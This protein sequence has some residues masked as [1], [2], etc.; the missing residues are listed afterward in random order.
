MM[1][2]WSE[3][4][5]HQGKLK[6]SFL[7]VTVEVLHYHLRAAMLDSTTISSLSPEEL[8]SFSCKDILL[9]LPSNM[10]AVT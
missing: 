9:F 10:A 8:D 3:I 2:M 7:L 1:V 5:Q 4:G 6:R